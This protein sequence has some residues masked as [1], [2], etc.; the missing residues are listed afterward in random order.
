[1]RTKTKN[2][3]RKNPLPPPPPP[4]PFKMNKMSEEYKKASNMIN[5]TGQ[6][7]LDEGAD[8]MDIVM[9]QLPFYYLLEHIMADHT[10]INP[11]FI[12]NLFHLH[13]TIC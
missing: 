6:G 12:Y 8:I 7:I 5:L 1:M 2:C 10:G 11:L 13:L 9:K 4:P 3:G